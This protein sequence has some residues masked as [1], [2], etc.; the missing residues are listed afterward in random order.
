MVLRR[1]SPKDGSLPKEA[2]SKVLERGQLRM[3]SERHT[4]IWKNEQVTLTVTEYP[5]RS[6][7]CGEHLLRMPGAKEFDLTSVVIGSEL[8]ADLVHETD[9]RRQEIISDHQDGLFVFPIV[10]SEGSD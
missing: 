1:S 8:N 2:D 10:M 3:D 6:S 5:F 9:R 7:E 4:C